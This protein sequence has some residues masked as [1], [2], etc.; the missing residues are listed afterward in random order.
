MSVF[1]TWHDIF[2][3][4]VSPSCSLTYFPLFPPFL[5]SHLVLLF[6]QHLLGPFPVFWFFLM[7]S[8]TVTQLCRVRMLSSGIWYQIP[9]DICVGFVLFSLSST[10]RTERTRKPQIHSPELYRDQTGNWSTTW[11]SV[12]SYTTH[13]HPTALHARPSTPF[14]RIN[15]FL[16]R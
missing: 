7:W 13:Y 5:V 14:H 8:N 2:L 3:F 16:L 15:K 10:A 6:V 12:W 11:R 1:W 4:Q 9:V